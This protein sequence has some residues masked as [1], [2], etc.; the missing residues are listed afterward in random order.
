MLYIVATPIGNLAD[1]SY[2]AIETLKTVDL[3][4]AEDTRRSKILLNHYQIH[5]YVTSF[6]EHNEQQVME[7]YISMLQQGKKIALVSDAGTPLISDPGYHLVRR[8]HLEKI[9]VSPIPGPSAM[10]AAISSSGLATD[11]FTFFGFLP[12]KISSKR[13][14]LKALKLEPKTMIFFESSHRI[15]VTLQEMLQIFGAN[16]AITFCRELTKQFETIIHSNLE[17]I[18][19]FVHADVNHQTKGEI[20]LVVAG[21]DMN[22]KRINLKHKFIANNEI[23][24]PDVHYILEE[25]VSE[26]PLSRAAKIAAKLTGIDK[27]HLYDYWLNID[28]K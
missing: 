6:H 18:Y 24:E 21:S 17:E 13:K 2:R 7:K 16:K 22:F 15:L 26:L 28:R 19:H 27:Q 25:L 14:I 1:L 5:T 3:I 23:M 11:Q 9:P 20:V 12:N 10:L 8:A 4:L